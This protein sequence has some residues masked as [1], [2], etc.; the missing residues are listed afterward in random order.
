MGAVFVVGAVVQLPQTQD[1]LATRVESKLAAAGIVV[2]AEFSGQDGT[3]HCTRALADPTQA[4]ALAQKVWG[5]R[6]IDVDVSCGVPGARATATTAPTSTP[7]STPAPTPT[8]ASTVPASTTGEAANSVPPTTSPSATVPATTVPP[9]SPDQFSLALK[10]GVFTLGGTVANDLERFV[11]VDRANAALSPSNVVNNL[12]ITDQADA[13]PATQ[14]TGLLDVMALMPANLASGA[15][16]WNGSEGTLAGSYVSDDGRDAL[17]AAAAE[18]GVVASLTPRATAT[19]EQAASLEAELNALVAAQPILFDK[20]SVDISLSSLGTVQQVAGI[21]KR[22]AGLSIEVQG[23]T[24]SEGDPGRNLTLSEQ[25][26]AAV[27][28]TLIALG[29]P[30]GDIT[31]KG[32]GVTQ[33]ILDSNGNELPDN[34]RRVVFGVSSI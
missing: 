19:A 9:A 24:D 3:L 12:T 29:V 17:E 16:G 27:R 28:D 5:V 26:A 1:D 22:F 15:L 23:H 31:S 11:L 13:V 8:T 33:L 18:S 6:S 30:S 14:F 2:R 34:S 10:D 32:F 25:R 21:A 4:L 20:G 7:T